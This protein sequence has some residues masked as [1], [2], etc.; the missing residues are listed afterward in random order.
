MPLYVLIGFDRD[1]ERGLEG[2]M[3]YFL[4]SMITSIAMLYGMTFIVG[5]SGTSAYSGVHVDGHAPIVMFAM[6]LLFA[7]LLA[8]LSA[9]PFHWWAPDAFAGAPAWSVAYVSAVPKMA[10]VIAV[11]RIV[12]VLVPTVPGLLPVLAASAVA[13]MVLGN[14]AAFP[15]TDIR[16][17]MA[18]SGVAHAGYILV[19]LTTG[20]LLGINAAIFY[21]LAYAIPSMAVMFVVADEG[22]EISDLVGL[23]KRRPWVA[24]T[25]TLLLISLIG[26]PP[27]VGFIGKVYIFSAAIQSNLMWLAVLGVTMSVVSAGFYFRIVRAMF[28][29]EAEEVKALGKGRTAATDIAL[30]VCVVATLGLGIA[31]SPLLNLIGLALP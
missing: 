4:L 12:Q 15:Q 23:A 10:G 11:A 5:L 20:T 14:L 22:T 30:V 18:Y 31:A 26:V 21:G 29:G 28:F 17:L 27:L 25:T 24:W 3:K 1:D 6:V 16:R 2:A 9:A 8:K 13:S 7:G 19:A